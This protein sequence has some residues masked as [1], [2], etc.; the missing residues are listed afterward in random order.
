MPISYDLLTR[1]MEVPES[2]KTYLEGKLQSIEHLID[3]GDP[4]LLCKVELSR[5]TEHHHAGKV[6]RAEINLSTGGKMVRAVAEG[7][8]LEEAVDE[9]KDELKAEL[10]KRKDKQQSLL[11]RSGARLKD[12]F[13]FR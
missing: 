5:T 4:T 11:R 9:V 7:E 8:T 1:N 3:A 10:G 13:R 2:F 12:I 6:F